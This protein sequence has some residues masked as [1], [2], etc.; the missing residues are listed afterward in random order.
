MS[1]LVDRLAEAAYK[2]DDIAESQPHKLLALR[3]LAADLAAE[4]KC[5]IWKVE[6]ATAEESNEKKVMS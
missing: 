1:S 6:Q 3:D 2:I 4:L 5:F